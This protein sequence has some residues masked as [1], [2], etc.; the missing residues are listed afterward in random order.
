M[1]DV[2][3]WADFEKVE[4][5]VGTIVAVEP[6]P[7]AKKPAYKVYVDFGAPLGTK[8]TSA[9]ITQN[10][11]LADLTGRQVLG[12]VNFP[13]KQIGGFMSEFL[14]LGIPDEEGH[15]VLLTT[16]RDVPNGGKVY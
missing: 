7:E 14:L 1:S 11:D 12:V 6:F 9:Q 5:R 2:I 10:Y 13:P 8:K 4:I 15:V 3:S 16:E